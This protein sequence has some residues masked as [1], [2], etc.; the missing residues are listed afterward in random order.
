MA[1]VWQW[2]TRNGPSRLVLGLLAAVQFWLILPQ[3]RQPLI[4]DDVN[5]AFAAEAVARTGLP[6][7]NAG[8]MSDRWD[9]SQREQ[10][11]L[12]HPPL[13]IYL[14]GLQFKLFG[15]SELSA[16]ALGVACGLVT[17]LLVYLIGRALQPGAGRAIARE[18]TGLLGAAFFLLNPLTI[19][20]ALILD[21]DG[22]ILTL[23]MTLMVYV[24]LRFPPE[25]HPRTLRVLTV[26]FALSLWAK[27]T[28]PLGLLGCLAAVRVLAGR[29]KQGI[30]EVLAIGVGGGAAFLL[31]WGL[32]CLTLGMP[33]DMPFAVTWIE[34]LD[35]AGTSKGWLQSPMTLAQ[36]LAVPVLWSGPFLALLFATAGLARLRGFAVTR[37]IQPVDLLIGF[38]V[39]IFAVYL[40]KMAGEFPKYHI[41][42]LPFWSAATAALVVAVVGRLLPIEAAL[43]AA[44]LVLFDWYFQRTPDVWVHGL[45]RG[46][47]AE[48][49]FFPALLA[50]LVVTALYLA[51]GRDLARNVVLVLVMMTLAWTSAVERGFGRATSSTTYFHGTS[52]QRDAAVVV[53]SLTRP[54][55]FYAA[56]K[57]VAWYAHNQRYLDQD[58]L[59]YFV[60]SAGGRFDGQ[61]VG[62][63]VR[64]LAL[65]VR[66]RDLREFYEKALAPAYD[67]VAERGDYVIWVRRGR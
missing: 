36:T 39:L 6:L 5:F 20:S 10:W 22:T 31:T 29:F 35:A 38:G 45:Y 33:F 17:A 46:I 1:S 48:L 9:F 47:F 67:R 58:T 40:I 61:L 32:A 2:A 23:L 41:A 50:C 14:L 44:G 24:L 64:V 54:G 52:G 8:H 55:E 11:A 4:Y 51:N 27:M 19:Q 37:K 30:R 12:W 65:W 16:R 3:L 18:A 56:A 34:L 28:T 60:S 26:L 59:E 43:T 63:D 7:A 15:V 49:G 66:P 25:S 62:Y 53:D 42:M 21:I 57:E 13:Y